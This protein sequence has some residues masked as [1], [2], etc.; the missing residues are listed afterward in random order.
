MKFLAILLLIIVPIQWEPNFE[1][2]K[3][4]AKEKNELILL[5][6]SG[7]DWCG[8][9]IILRKSYLENDQFTTMASDHLI[10]VNADFPRNKKKLGTADQIKRNEALAEQYNSKGIFPLTLLLNADG[11]ILK[12]WEGKPDVS[13]EKWVEEIK[14]ICESNK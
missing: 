14:S 6:F 13:V 4:L 5:N 8:P 3:K 9:C 10:L 1:N 12:S 7:S 2:A 11:K